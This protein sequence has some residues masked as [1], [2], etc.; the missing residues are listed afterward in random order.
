MATING[1][2]VNFGFT[3]TGGIAITG[4]SGILLQSAEDSMEAD[5]E[6]VRSAAGDIVNRNWYDQHAKSQLEWVVTG[7]GLANAITNT[8][9]AGLVPGTIVVI[10]ACA[11]MP[12]LVGTTW[13]VMSGAREHGSNTTSKRITVPLEKRAG[14]TAAAGA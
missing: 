6:D 2:A 9:L 3:G 14:I 10:S 1:T 11:S 8:T 4:L 5:K 12:D 13:E 7:T